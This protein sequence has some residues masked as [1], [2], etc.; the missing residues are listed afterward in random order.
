[1]KIVDKK[2]GKSYLPIYW[3]DNYI[4][5]LPHSKRNI[6]GT[7][8]MPDHKHLPKLIINGWNVIKTEK[9]IL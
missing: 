9:M 4:S 3:T 8:R 1:M 7:F 5:L 2:T 6:T